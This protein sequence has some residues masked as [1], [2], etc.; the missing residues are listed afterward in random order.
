V[1][2]VG[3]GRVERLEPEEQRGEASAAV[4]SPKVVAKNKRKMRTL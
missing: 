2:A 1:I 4:R 3:D